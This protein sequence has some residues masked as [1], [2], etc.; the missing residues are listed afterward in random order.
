MT[1]SN[2]AEATRTSTDPRSSIRST[3]PTNGRCQNRG[4]TDQS[5]TASSGIDAMPVVTWMPWLTA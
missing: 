3:P 5:F 2:T 4:A 1:S